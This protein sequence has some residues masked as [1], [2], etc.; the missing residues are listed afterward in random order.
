MIELTPKE[1]AEIEY[2][3]AEERLN[4]QRYIC[5]A[6]RTSVDT[7]QEYIDWSR[8][9]EMIVQELK[10]LLDGANE[11]LLRREAAFSVA[12]SNLSQLETRGLK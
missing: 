1:M 11:E 5:E 8:A 9:K 2:E 10:D 6:L 4:E 3:N 7:V 12:E